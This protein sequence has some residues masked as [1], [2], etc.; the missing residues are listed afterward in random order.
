MLRSGRRTTSSRAL[1]EPDSPAAAKFLTA[2]AAVTKFP[3]VRRL[4]FRR[5]KHETAHW[6]MGYTSRL[7]AGYDDMSALIR[8]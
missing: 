3:A 2:S 8:R 6:D 4:L 5:D 7:A 1:T